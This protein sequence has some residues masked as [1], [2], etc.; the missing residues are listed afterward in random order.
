MM[1]KKVTFLTCLSFLTCLTFL[2]SD[3]FAQKQSTEEADQQI[4][5]FS[6]VG[7]GEKGQKTWDLTG[8]TADIFEKFSRLF[9]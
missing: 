7:Y 4:S 3:S 9:L 5:E 1:S 6:L 8:Q 2:T